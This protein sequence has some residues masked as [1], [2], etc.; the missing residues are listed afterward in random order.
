[1][2][3]INLFS[4]FA[5]LI[6]PS[7]A[8]ANVGIPSIAII[9]PF[10]W[11]AFIPVVFIEAFSMR[12]AL[13]SYSFGKLLFYNT[14]SNAASTFVG[15]P[16]AYTIMFVLTFY[17][18]NYLFP[19]QEGVLLD[20]ILVSM[21]MF[22]AYPYQKLGIVLLLGIFFLISVLVER[23]VF[24][25]MVGEEYSKPLIAQEVFKANLASYAFLVIITISVLMLFKI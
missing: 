6:I 25:K 13:P 10:F 3:R 4:A 5:L 7:M 14:A 12:R 23:W 22:T 17:G 20:Q 11:L 8:C 15:I 1:M 24:A 21:F 2:K 19:L 16:I 9:W 18:F